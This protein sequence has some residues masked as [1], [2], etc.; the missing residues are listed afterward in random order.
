M[1]NCIYIYVYIVPAAADAGAP[2]ALDDAANKKRIFRYI[3]STI[4]IYCKR[5]R[6]VLT[7]RVF[8]FGTA[9]CRA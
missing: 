5:Y 7:Q 9:T 2:R 3:L 6:Y 8:F 1:Y 4:F